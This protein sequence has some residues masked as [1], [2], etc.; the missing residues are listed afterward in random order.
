MTQNVKEL[1]EETVELYPD[2]TKLTVTEIENIQTQY[3]KNNLKE[4][5]SIYL[6]AAFTA[7]FFFALI[8]FVFSK[9][10][11]YLSFVN[12]Y[13]KSHSGKYSPEFIEV[14]NYSFAISIFAILCYLFLLPFLTKVFRS[15]TNPFPFDK[16]A[17]KE[18]SYILASLIAVY[19]S[20]GLI[21]LLIYLNNKDA[22]TFISKYFS[23]YLLL[24][25]C[26]IVSI[27]LLFFLTFVLMFPFRRVIYR[28][29]TSMAYKRAD[30]CVR[31]MN[32]LK[33]LHS[34]DN[35]YFLSTKDSDFVIEN[36]KKVCLLIKN[37][38]NNVLDS[39]EN[40]EIGR[41]FFKASKEFENNID[42]FISTKESHS[43]NI[44]TSLVFCLNTFLAGDLTTLPT[45]EV[46][47]E[48]SIEKKAKLIHYLL[49][50]L[51]LT[52]PII[53]ILV[54]K[55]IFKIS[56][57]EYT[58][59]LMKILYIIWAFIGIFS[60]PFVLNSDSKELLKDM[61]KTLTGKS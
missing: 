55:H 46:I 34:F 25:L 54:L 19:I 18:P 4:K 50:A 49:L 59:S 16:I 5:T 41:H 61:L 56:L 60:N 8:P 2:V 53:V 3:D 21:A 52:L 40:R 30:I 27:L 39:F 31:I 37:Y 23:Y 1:Y 47:P 13:L 17:I 45:V 38:P 58:Q 26:V 15:K 14:I 51:Y 44:K 57:D 42:T 22:A 6:M 7:T 29:R 33:K 48:V 12:E 36:L 11:F 43:Q 9:L 32:V 28:N 10:S 35:Y 20:I 24:P